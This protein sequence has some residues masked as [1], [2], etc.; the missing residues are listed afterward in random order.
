MCVQ[1]GPLPVDYDHHKWL[2]IYIGVARVITLLIE[3]FHTISNRFLGY[4]LWILFMFARENNRPHGL[5]Y[6][7]LVMDGVAY[8]KILLGRLGADMT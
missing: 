3:I 7:Q 2:Y 5:R 6:P 4:I 1:D 8:S